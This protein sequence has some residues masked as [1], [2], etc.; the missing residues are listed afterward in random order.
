MRRSRCKLRWLFLFV[1]SFDCNTLQR[2][3][4]PT[5]FVNRVKGKYTAMFN[6]CS[7]TSHVKKRNASKHG[8]NKQTKQPRLLG[9]VTT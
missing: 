6:V 2:V 4:S 8:C 5:P 9:T 7:S 1:P 3:G